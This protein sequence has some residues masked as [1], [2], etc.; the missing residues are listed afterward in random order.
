MGSFP[1]KPH[2][3]PI[4]A[5]RICT[6]RTLST[7]LAASALR[8]ALEERRDNLVTAATHDPRAIEAMANATAAIGQPVDHKMAIPVKKLWKPGSTLKVRLLGKP[9]AHV[10]DRVE[11]YAGVWSDHASIRFRFVAKG[12]AQIRVAFDKR[13][14]SWSYL[15]TDARLV[16][17][18]K[19]TMNYGWLDDDTSESEFAR[20]V[21]HEFGHALGAI[22]EHNHPAAG[23]PWN[24]PAVYAYYRR[25]QGWSAA[26]VDAQVFAVYAA[27]QLNAGAYD[28]ASIMH[29]AIPRELLLPGATP[30]AWNRQLSRRDRAFIRSQY[31]PRR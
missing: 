18:S 16:R 28:R 23:I 25:T 8:A 15:G 31:P 26:D 9:S 20:V 7:R 27:D 29:Y 5:I 1:R 17:A 12:T 4:D 10:A 13:S 30:V 6:D 21:L 22:H 19:A 24:R 3:P 14:G 11:H 2:A